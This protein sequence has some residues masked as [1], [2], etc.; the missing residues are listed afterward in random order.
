MSRVN[1]DEVNIGVGDAEKGLN[2][3]IGPSQSHIS[4]EHHYRR[5][6]HHRDP[7]PFSASPSTSPGSFGFVTKTNFLKYKFFTRAFA[8]G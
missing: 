5:R 6:A 1:V 2:R 3:F 4:A 8:A 7:Y